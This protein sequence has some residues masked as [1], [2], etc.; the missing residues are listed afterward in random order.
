MGVAGADVSAGV[1]GLGNKNVRGAGRF[2]KG[3]WRFKHF[4][5]EWGISLGGGG[6]PNK[7]GYWEGIL[8]PLTKHWGKVWGWGLMGG[9]WSRI[10]PAPP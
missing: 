3:F 7:L 4:S 2:L 9:F 10:S 1:H 5:G 6:I 8:F